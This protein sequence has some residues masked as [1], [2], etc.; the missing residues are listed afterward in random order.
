MLERE[1]VEKWKEVVGPQV[2]A[3]T[4]AER[5]RDGI[6][7]VCC[8]SS[9]WSSELSFYKDDIVKRLNAAVGRN[10]IT[11]I[12]FSAKGF[13]RARQRESSEDGVVAQAASEAIPVQKADVASQTMRHR[14]R[15]Q[16]IWPN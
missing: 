4:G 7:F 11:D 13:T 10:L 9:M 3:S 15:R 8:K 2:A 1:A 6:L 5:V 16:R 12:R 14:Q